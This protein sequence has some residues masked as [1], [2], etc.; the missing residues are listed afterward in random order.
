MKL[1]HLCYQVPNIEAAVATSEPFG[2]HP[3]SRPLPAPL[4]GNRRVIW[5]YSSNYGLF[6]LIETGGTASSQ[7]LS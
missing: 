2:F 1:L 7:R 4:Y 6:E 5:V 3:I